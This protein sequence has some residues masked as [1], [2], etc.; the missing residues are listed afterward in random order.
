MSVIV[1]TPFKT[2]T[3]GGGFSSTVT[4][5]PTSV[6]HILS[7]DNLTINPTTT[8]LKTA[9]ATASVTTGKYYWE[10]VLN[11]G[12]SKEIWLGIVTSAASLTT[13]AGGDVNGYS[14]YA[15]ASRFYS[16]GSFE[17]IG[18]SYNVG[19]TVSVLLDLDTNFIT[20]WKGGVEAFAPKPIVSGTY[21]PAVSLYYASVQ[22]TS[23]FGATP[24]TYTPPAG[25][26]S[27]P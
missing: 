25:Y 22:I 17:S 2:T 27:I 1:T 5:D 19:D 12:A 10:S 18:N 11:S 26:T 6:N 20:F 14:W 8:G 16:H 21:F 13:Y 24:F 3:T 7:P 15:A 4:W 23:N 9:I